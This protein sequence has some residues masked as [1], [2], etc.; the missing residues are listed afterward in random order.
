MPENPAVV[1]RQSDQSLEQEEKQSSEE[2]RQR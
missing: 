2:R 1:C